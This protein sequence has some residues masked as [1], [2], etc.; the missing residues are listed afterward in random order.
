MKTKHIKQQKEIGEK[1]CLVLLSKLFELSEKIMH[2]L[3]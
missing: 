1:N 3:K 2:K